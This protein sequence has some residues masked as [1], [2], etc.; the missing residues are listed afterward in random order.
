[1]GFFDRAIV[2]VVVAL[3]PRV[4]AYRLA[5]A[6][7]SQARVTERGAI[8]AMPSVQ[9]RFVY[10]ARNGADCGAAPDPARRRIAQPRLAIIFPAILGFHAAERV[11]VIVI[12]RAGNRVR[13]AVES[14]FL[15]PRKEFLE[16][17]VAEM[18]KQEFA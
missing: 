7:E 5:S 1:L 13:H 12:E 14:E 18:A 17:L 3:E 6:D 9:H 4:A 16:V 15:Q 11:R 10:F 2:L 8:V